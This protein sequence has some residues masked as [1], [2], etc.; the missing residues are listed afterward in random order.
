MV[1]K[2]SV[3]DAVES[4]RGLKPGEAV[5]VEYAS[6]DPVHLAVSLPLMMAGEG[7]KVVVNDILDQLH[8]IRAHLEI[9]GIPTGWINDLPVIKFG[10]TIPVGNVIKR[11][12]ILKPAPVWSREY[13][14]ALASIPGVKIV[15]T[16]GIEKMINV[17]SDIPASTV[18][19]TTGATSLGAEDRIKVTFVNRDLLDEGTLEDIRELATRVFRLKFQEGRMIMEVI[20]SPHMKSYGKRFSLDAED[21][22]RYLQAAGARSM[23]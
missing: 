18:C 10:G 1:I 2:R 21:L 22:V 11:I 19:R 16:L 15:V 7:M 20:K 14:E 13:E 3:L 5:V 12:S 9:L 17:K 6:R 4:I 23:K 8:V